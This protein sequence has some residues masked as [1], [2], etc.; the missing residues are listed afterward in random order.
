MK[1]IEFTNEQETDIIEMYKNYITVADITKKYNVN[2]TV[3]YNLLKANGIELHGEKR[4]LNF[5][6]VEDVINMY[7]N[8]HTLQDIASK[9]GV[10]RW[11]VKRCLQE[12]KIGL[13]SRAE[14]IRQY[15]INENFFDEI[16]TP[17]KA[18]VIGLLWSDGCNKTDRGT[19][20]LKLQ[21]EDKHI[22]EDIKKLIHTDRPLY[23]CQKTSDSHQNMYALEVTNKHI[24]DVLDR[25]GMKS[26]KS[27]TLQFPEWL[28]KTLYNSFLR[29][30]VDGDGC[31]FK[32]SGTYCVSIV[33]TKSLCEYIQTFL[34]SIDINSKIY[35]YNNNGVTVSL[36]ISGKNNSSKFLDFIYKDATIYLKRK[37]DIYIS[38]YCTNINN[39]LPA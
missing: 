36:Y 17:E 34:K 30:I 6:Q 5:V 35:S 33:G 22:L 27:L 9:Y 1:K 31:I 29:G 25:L 4:V 32:A 2:K 26:A 8:G 39:S 23:Y 15:N 38:K 13:R 16:N 3:V 24:S 18:Y 14:S 21:E 20:T 19:V 28:D 10:N 12:N 37:Y 11:T 7:I